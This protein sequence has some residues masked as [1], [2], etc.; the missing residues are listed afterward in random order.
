M[1]SQ[2]RPSARPEASA[3]GSSSGSAA[4]SK[5]ARAKTSHLH[6]FTDFTEDQLAT[7]ANELGK[8]E[9]E[10]A[11]VRRGCAHQPRSLCW[12]QDAVYAV[13]T[14]QP[15]FYLPRVIQNLPAA[16]SDNRKQWMYTCLLAKYYRVP[17]NLIFSAVRPYNNVISPVHKG[18]KKQVELDAYAL[19]VLYTAGLFIDKRGLLLDRLGFLKPYPTPHHRG[20]D[21]KFEESR[22]RVF[23]WYDDDRWE[24]YLP[25]ENPDDMDGLPRDVKV[26]VTLVYSR[27][28]GLTNAEGGGTNEFQR[29]VARALRTL[30][31]ESSEGAVDEVAGPEEDQMDENQEAASQGAYSRDQSPALP[32]RAF[33][34]PQE[35]RVQ[36]QRAQQTHTRERSLHLQ[37]FQAKLSDALNDLFEAEGAQDNHDY[38]LDYRLERGERRDVVVDAAAQTRDDPAPGRAPH[39][40]EDD[41]RPALE[42]A[43]N[44]MA[45]N[46]GDGI[47]EGARAS[48]QDA[49]PAKRESPPPGP[50]ARSIKRELGSREAHAPKEESPGAEAQPGPDENVRRRE[51]AEQRAAAL[52]RKFEATREELRQQRAQ[53]QQLARESRREQARGRKRQ[54]LLRGHVE[55]IYRKWDTGQLL[56]QAEESDGVEGALDRVHDQLDRLRQAMAGDRARLRQMAE[57]EDGAED[58]RAQLRDWVARAEADAGGRMDALEELLGSD[59]V[60][61][62]MD[63]AV[64][65][66]ESYAA[67]VQTV[68]PRLDR[69]QSGA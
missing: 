56:Q 66:K 48:D 19:C 34:E 49:Q 59:A 62:P 20:F 46:E 2:A 6:Y 52:K 22:D 47:G 39:D 63:V 51:A 36:D 25:E 45:S 9:K 31:R 8:W 11:C 68:Q 42:E 50:A 3:A 28:L 18:R 35:H 13:D 69:E 30:L 65:L 58:V 55:S 21:W 57:S 16:L 61:R 29:T 37:L 38:R 54:K 17:I 5:P 32:Q 1:P 12:D 64:E 14:T 24:E 7:L 4:Q 67:W 43:G 27:F 53:Y 60:A 40:A 33:S 26:E 10:S 44:Q 15:S 23:R 41:E